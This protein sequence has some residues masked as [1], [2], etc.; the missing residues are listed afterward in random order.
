[1]GGSS[2]LQTL[3]FVLLLVGLTPLLGQ[4]MADVFQGKKTAISFLFIRLE[5][6]CYRLGGIDSRREMYWRNYLK[7]LLLFNLLGFGA[8]FL[9]QLIQQWLPLNPQSFPSVPW[10][11]AFNTAASF[12]TNTNWQA[13][14]GET[15][16]SYITQ[17]LGLTVQNFLSAATGMG[18]LLVLIR[19]ITN[20][21][22]DLLGSFWVDLVRSI[23][24][25]LLPLAILMAIALVGTGVIQNFSSYIHVTTLE[26]GAQS[27][28]MGPVASQVA[29]KQLGTNGGGFFNA[30]SAHPV[31]NPSGLSNFLESLAIILIPASLTY[32]YGAMLNSQKHGWLIF[33]VMFV[34][35]SGGL[36]VSSY[37][38]SRVEPTLAVYPALEGQ[39][40]RFQGASSLLWTVSTTATANGSVNAMISSLSPLAGGLAMFNIMLGE[41]V[42]GGVGV[43][44]CGMIMY[45]LLTVFLSGLMVG[46]TPEF[47]G[48]K[49]EKAEMQ[50]VI[51]AVLIP[52]ALILI[53]SGIS[54]ISPGALSSLAN[55][56][57][58]GLSELL[59]AFTSAAGNNGSAFAGLNANTT[60]YNLFL[61]AIMLLGRLAIIVPSIAIAG[62]LAKKKTMPPSVGTFSSDTILF[63]VL[64]LSVMLIVV[65]LTFFP[66]LALG[67]IV[68]HFLMQQGRVF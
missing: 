32:T 53:G 6:L 38:Q 11:L 41:V 33:L 13:Y 46:R 55:Q 52:S 34:V 26:N 44:L 18:A 61:G 5:L 14:A 24:Y 57:P 8:L 36:A 66:A 47:M 2:W 58:H 7:A 12:T 16:L 37:F 23:V 51:A 45:I 49:I 48:K 62:L 63:I 21:S 65:A 59:Y 39:E 60:Y 54:S 9:L 40:T 43:G 68:E 31:E 35:W 1:M 15:T 17:M 4:Y 30:N 22:K 3:L 20:S 10:D 42:F 67:P 29:I 56:G 64:L 19:G 27:I 25:L 28:P 50:W